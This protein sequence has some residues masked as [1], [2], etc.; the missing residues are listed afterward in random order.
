MRR[1]DGAAL[2]LALLLGTA[3]TAAATATWRLAH[4][5]LAGA[6]YAHAAT[7]A[8]E[9]ADAHAAGYRAVLR[10]AAAPRD[11]ASAGPPSRASVRA[12]VERME[13]HGLPGGTL[14]RWEGTSDGDGWRVD[15]EVEVRRG[16]AVARA[17]VRAAAP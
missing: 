5:D 2:A 3:L 7:L 14:V 4:V 17:T 13:V 9:A 8:R 12:S 11:A 6:R 16:R 1:R 10:H 15:A